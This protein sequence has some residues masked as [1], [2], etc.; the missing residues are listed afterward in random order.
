[1]SPT[2]PPEVIIIGAG[3]GGLSAA[4]DLARSC[5]RVLVLER[6]NL[7]GGFA[8]SFKRGRFEFEPSLHELGASPA[9]DF[10]KEALPDLTFCEVPEA[11]R[12][13]LT[14]EG[15]NF[16]A[17]YGPA[18]FT[19]AVIDATTCDEK[20]VRDFMEI[21]AKTFDAFAY[22]GE[23][24]RPNPKVLTGRFGDFLRTGASV[25]DE[26]ADSVGLPVEA[27]NL[28]Y[29]YWCYLGVGTHRVSFSI[30]GSLIHSYLKFGAVIPSTRSHG[31]TAGMATAIADN[32]GRIRYNAEVRHVVTKGKRITG[33]SLADGEQI[34]CDYLISNISHHRLFGNLIDKP[35]RRS[36]K[37][38]NARSR[39]MSLFVVYLA[40][41]AGMEEMG[42]TD[43]SY[44]IAPHMNT[45]DL[46]AK[47]FNRF[48]PEPMQASI[49][50]NAA[51]PTASPPG[52]TILSITV[53]TRAEAWA[54]VTPQNYHREKMRLAELL[55]DQFERATG[56]TL[57][58]HIEE[59]ETAAPPTFS[60]YTGSWD[61]SVYG[62]EP[63]PWDG[64]LPRVLSQ[65]K[66]RFYSNL[67]YAGG[68]AYRA[69]GYGSS[70][71]SGR[72]AAES[73]MEAKK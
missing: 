69:Y 2:T 56:I 21:C 44:F 71:M 1:M 52:T 57:R 29:P 43:Y 45:K 19:Q 50:L 4:L 18:E 46:E 5:V 14:D 32:G 60:R 6:H 66:E 9:V 49:C 64:I 68:N 47:V 42:F 20:P 12:V 59:I 8:T 36:L 28:I 31:I 15:V 35:P 16:R 55:I 3:L 11:Y 53:G 37:L 41:D 48:D 33:V 67:R 38:L 58:G 54:D 25:P 13:I 72:S 65:G 10:L 63:E 34:D 62:Y 17:P 51:D 23:N 7:P 27:R 30:W 39:G 73:I 61:G 24:P 40:L 26:V 22:L 70:I